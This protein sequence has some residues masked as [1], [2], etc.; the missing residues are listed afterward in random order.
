MEYL[1]D[2]HVFLW[3]SSDDPALGPVA[4]A[5][6]AAP[7]NLVLVSGATAWEIATKREL[8]KLDAPADVAAWVAESG[9]GELPIDIAHAVRS[10][11]L[12]KRHRDPFDRLL[13]AQSQLES[14]TLVTSDPEIA[15]YEVATLDA[16]A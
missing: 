7:E 3:W 4:R 2:T 10:A 8:G 5:A 6:I 16:A 9:F 11:E 14:L 13:V 1:L 15:K 12:P